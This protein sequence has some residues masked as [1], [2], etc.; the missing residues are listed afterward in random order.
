MRGKILNVERARFDKMLSSAEIGTL[1]TALGTG[2]GAE[3]FDIKKAR[4]HKIIIMTDADVDGSHIRTLLLTF[5]YRQMPELIESGYLYIAQPPLYRAK[6]GK[7]EVYLKDDQALEDYLINAG[8]EDCILTIADG[9]QVVGQ[10]LKALI[11]FSRIVKRQIAGLTTR[12]PTKI[13]EQAA[14]AGALNPQILSDANQADQA[15]TYIASRIDALE[16][17]IEK[18][19]KG[20]SLADGGLSFIRVLRGVPD[21]PHVIDGVVIRSSEARSLD[22]N[23]AEL[24]QS[25]IGHGV[26]K[27]KDKEFHITGP[28]SLF[29]TILELGRQ[30]VSMQRYKGLGEMNP[31]QLWET[32]LDPNVRT[33]LQVKSSHADEAED[34]FSTLM[35]DVVELRR[36]FIQENALKV[37][38]LDI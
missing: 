29:E 7:S 6:L 1:I 37:A 23:T 30:G 14:I 25:F 8:I 17:E 5:F 34:V 31:E 11:E 16:S 35:G 22:S 9:S 26:L 24:Q 27:A 21:G 19:W 32:T 20:E 18:G 33:L 36:E 28:I 3:D 2:I 38:N 4:Y 15:A 13:S 10:D 12:V